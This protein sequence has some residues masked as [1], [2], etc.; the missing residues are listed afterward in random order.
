[1]RPKAALGGTLILLLVAVLLMRSLGP[2]VRAAEVIDPFGPPTQPRVV[3]PLP[4]A[5]TP[6]T[7]FYGTV[8]MSGQPARGT[9]II[10]ALV[11]GIVCGTG[12]VIVLPS[13]AGT[14][15][16]YVVDVAS[17]F[18]QAGCGANGASVSFTVDGVLA[19]ERGTF[20]TGAFVPLNLTAVP[21]T[22]P[23]VVTAVFL[24]ARPD[25]DGVIRADQVIIQFRA[26]DAA[27]PGG[28]ATG[29]V[30]IVVKA[31]GVTLP[32]RWSDVCTVRETVAGMETFEYFAVD[33]AGNRSSP[34]TVMITLE[35]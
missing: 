29:V 10:R 7:R 14:T 33:G 35:H 5:A 31:D 9:A 20:E 27:P 11:D 34:Q 3:T 28:Q 21:D 15:T 12:S 6:P 22:V 23:P 32:C 19:N 2:F 13:P 17:A 25:P 30:Q 4:G 8:V 18:T 16:S 24:S 1:M 26:T